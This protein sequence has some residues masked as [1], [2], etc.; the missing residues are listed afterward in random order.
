MAASSR[1]K[2]VEGRVMHEFAH[3]EL[4]SGPDGKA[5]PVKSRK[6]AIA[7]ALSQ[8]GDSRFKTPQSNRK[9]LA[10]TRQKEAKGE[11][12]EQ[13]SEGRD[14][15]GAQDERES[16]RPMGGADARRPTA[17]GAKAAAARARKPDGHSLVQL[18]ALAARREVA[19]RSR[20]SKQQLKNALGLE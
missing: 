11:T 19:G 18:R 15:L 2:R 6:Q 12:A 5:G 3:G 8:A 13:E 4:K 9:S 7:I 10:R 20:M 17:R 1:Q 14:H 16:T